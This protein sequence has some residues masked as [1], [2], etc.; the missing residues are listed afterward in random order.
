MATAADEQVVSWPTLGFLA[1]DWI[2][3]HCVVP[4]GFHKGDPFTMYDWQLWCTV[5]HYR[6]KPDAKVGQLAPAFYYRRSQIVAP[7]KT[8]K[9]PWSASIT[10]NEAVG[11]A[12]FNGWAQ[13][14]EAYECRDWGCGCGWYWEY[15]P[16]D[17][18]GRPWPTPLIQLLATSEDQ[19]D[20]VYRP[21]QAM[22]KSGPLSALMRVGEEFIRLPNDGKIE[23]VTSSALSRLGNPI[24]FALQDE[25][26]LYT[27]TNKMVRVAETQ[28]RGAAGM[29]GRTME[30]TNAWD[31]SEESVAQRTAESQ[32]PDIFRFHRIPPAGLRYGVKAERRKIHRH[33]YKGSPHVDLDAI[34]AEA[35]ELLEKDPQQAERF[36]GN[37]IVYGAGHYIDG[38]LWDSRARPRTVEPGTPI[39]LGFDGSDSDDYTGFRAETA[40][41]YQFTPTYGP[42]R[43]PAVWDPA[44]YGGQV[45]RLEVDAALD[46]IMS[47][48][49]V[50]RMYGD[51]PYWASELDAWAEKYGA[52]RVL[53]W[54]TYRVAQMHSAAERLLVDVAKADSP[55]THDGCPITSVHVKNARKAA[56]PAQRYVLTKPSQGQ[57]IDQCVISILAHEAAGDAH[58][59]GLFRVRTRSSKV[60]VMR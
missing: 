15:E 46:E 30:T 3:A 16:G 11:P 8:G 9:G 4:D 25:T 51:P 57:K 13:G 53:R 27:K 43:L 17:P 49:K 26:G 55:L 19:V 12:V 34:E 2:E 36:Y 48:Y 10:C 7:Q 56:R 42:D 41:G 40:D 33:V 5:N 39:V 47:T 21:L 58:A 60:I 59:A 54:A 50:V 52:T 24:I 29:G 14:G 38:D 44:R 1:A 35:A 20:N 37:R 32:R 28:R 18:M 45:P 23:I 31:P 22:I 6:V